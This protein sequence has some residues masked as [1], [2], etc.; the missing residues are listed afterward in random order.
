[1]TSLGSRSAIRCRPL[2]PR[3]CRHPRAHVH[4]QVTRVK[5]DWD[6]KARPRPALPAA[7]AATGPV[8]P[9]LV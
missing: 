7:T 8:P 1:M 2:R 9:Q 3:R 6:N 4:P 5:F